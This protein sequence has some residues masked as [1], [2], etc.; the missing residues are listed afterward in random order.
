MSRVFDIDSDE[1]FPS[2]VPKLVRMNGDV[3]RHHN[4]LD[5]I[6]ERT[7]QAKYPAVMLAELYA[8][9]EIDKEQYER[10]RRERA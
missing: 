8:A 1:P 3:Y 6:R 7:A 9:G 4:L 2:P 5:Y 10:L